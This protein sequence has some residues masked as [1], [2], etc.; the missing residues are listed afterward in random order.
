MEKA[1]FGCGAI[2][3]LVMIAIGNIDARAEVTTFLI[4]I[5]VACGAYVSALYLIVSRKKASRRELVVCLVLCLVWRVPLLIS[6]PILSDDVYRYIWD[7]RIQKFG[8]NPYASV[9]DDP[10]LRDLHTPITRNIHPTS[11]RLPTIYPPA[12]QLFFRGVTSVHES[13]RAMTLAVLVCD[14]LVIAILLKWLI[15]TRRNPFWV[16]A[17]AWH[18]LVAVEGAGAAHVDFLGVLFV[19][20]A[21]Y[22]L[23]RRW[24]MVAT[25]SLAVA[26]AVKFLPIVLAPLLWRRVRIRDA[27][28]SVGFVFLIFLPFVRDTGWFPTGSLSVYLEEWRFNGLV[29][30][31]LEPLLGTTGTLVLTIISGLVVAGFSRHW[32]P[33]DAPGAWAWPLATTLLLMPVIY[34]WYLI[35]LTPFLITRS[36]APLV[37]WS[38]GVFLTYA[39]WHAEL[40]GAGWVLPNWVKPVEYGLVAVVAVGILCTHRLGLKLFSGPFLSD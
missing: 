31:W 18:P 4:L 36:T 32:L 7:G 34:P 1:L 35:W 40:N 8:H 24:S 19:V 39:V 12:T 16:L 23:A 14:I 13:V 28:L 5:A 17:Y 33:Q 29:F 21:A 26:V 37:A 11:A 25:I 38:F 3:L 2:I 10:Q 20:L 9:P 15:A 22:A 27:M 30:D 6:S